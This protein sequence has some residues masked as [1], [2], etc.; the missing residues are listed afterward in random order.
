MR[1][2]GSIV[3][4]LCVFFMAGASR[5]EDV[6]AQ[7]AAERGKERLIQELASG[8][9]NGATQ[10]AIGAVVHE[11]ANTLR[12]EGYAAEANSL[13]SEWQSEYARYFEPGLSIL[14]VGDFTP[15]S[16]WLGRTY[17]RLNDRFGWI[18]RMV[19]ILRDINTL[20]YTIPVVFHPKG[21]PH[22]GEHWDQRDYRLHF[23]PF[24]GVTSYWVS[25]ETCRLALT[26]LWPLGYVCS[27]PAKLISKG[28]ERW[29]APK[30]SERIYSRA[31]GV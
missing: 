15:V 18:V 1:L 7:T 19:R 29:I 27:L 4:A 3:A 23:T 5:A 21:N 22:T 30:L 31:N 16:E 24:S 11:A 20:N 2:T 13:E 17:R 28:V 14:E 12:D 8:Q 9:F 6:T 25:N 26:A 10:L